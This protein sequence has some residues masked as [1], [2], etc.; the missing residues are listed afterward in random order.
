MARAAR[1]DDWDQRDDP[2]V[3]G[4]ARRFPDDDLADAQQRFWQSRATPDTAK[5]FRRLE[6][7]AWVLDRSIPIGR[8]RIGLDPLLGLMPGVGDSLGAVLSSYVL[9]EAARLGAPGGL[10][11]RMAGNILLESALGVIPLLGDLFDAYWKANTRNMA[12]LHRHYHVHWQ[13]RSLTG[14]WVSVLVVVLLLIAAVI[15]AA[16]WIF[17]KLAPLL[18]F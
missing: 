16:W 7:L 13:P 9:Y 3:F 17:Q 2:P 12:L 4:E 10:L 11:L 6:R 14:V 15:G 5:R 8:F 1:G 18:P